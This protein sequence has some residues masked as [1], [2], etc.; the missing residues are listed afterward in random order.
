MHFA[1]ISILNAHVRT[2]TNKK[3]KFQTQLKVFT[4]AHAVRERSFRPWMKAPK[5]FVQNNANGHLFDDYDIVTADFFVR[6]ESEGRKKKTTHRSDFSRTRRGKKRRERKKGRDQRMLDEGEE[7]GR[8]ER[9]KEEGNMAEL[10]RRE[11]RKERRERR[12]WLEGIIGEGRRERGE[13]SFVCVTRAL[14]PRFFFLR[15]DFN[16][17]M[18]DV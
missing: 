13:G 14:S 18:G 6:S 7:E 1:D 5:A 11:G 12:C 15:R 17:Y 2:Q 10:S 8:N 16:S 3:K 9:K 4:N